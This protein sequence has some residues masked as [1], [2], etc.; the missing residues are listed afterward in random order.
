MPDMKYGNPQVAQRYSKCPNYPSVN[1]AGVSEMFRQVGDLQLDKDGIAT[2]GLL[3]R[4]LV[5]PNNLAGTKAVISY[6]A[7]HISK[8]TYLNIMDQ[9]RP[10]H[11]ARE[12]PQLNR[13]ITAQEYQSAVE[14]AISCGLHRLDHR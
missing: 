9:Y 4:H 2:R 1:Q 10:L 8:D 5:L 13:P 12:Y 6:L 14:I 11:R 3:V 7:E